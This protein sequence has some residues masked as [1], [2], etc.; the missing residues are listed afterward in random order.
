MCLQEDFKDDKQTDDTDKLNVATSE[1]LPATLDLL[2]DLASPS[3]SADLLG[4]TSPDGDE[5][6][7]F[8][9]A[10]GQSLIPY[11]P[12]QLL[13][14]DVLVDLSSW[15]AEGA[16]AEH[17]LQQQAPLSSSSS[18]AGEAKSSKSSILG[19]FGRGANASSAQLASN[20][21]GSSKANWMDLFAELDP[22]ANPDLME[23]KLSGSHSNS[24][25]A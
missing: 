23:K 10:A 25:A 11:M 22:L 14:D 7:E 18:A 12:S 2:N 19:L 15:S 9:S 13:L 5:F 20:K 17:Q 8:I 4:L 16:A 24:Q 21:P 3:P 6:G 1:L